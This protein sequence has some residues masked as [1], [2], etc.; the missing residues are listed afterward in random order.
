MIYDVDVIRTFGKLHTKH[1]CTVD[2]WFIDFHMARA[3]I[4]NGAGGHFNIDLISSM[5]T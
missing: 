4:F 1:Y 3:V 5:I 2:F